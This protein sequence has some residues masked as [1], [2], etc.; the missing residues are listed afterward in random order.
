MRNSNVIV[1][2][3]NDVDN[4]IIPL[5]LEFGYASALQLLFF[6]IGHLVT[7]IFQEILIWKFDKHSTI[8]II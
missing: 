6:M 7:S 4:K 5:V 2:V 3:D 8:K 1:N